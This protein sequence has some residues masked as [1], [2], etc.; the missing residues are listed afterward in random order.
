M[1]HAT[2]SDEGL[3]YA[4]RVYDDRQLVDT[5]YV[6]SLSMEFSDLRNIAREDD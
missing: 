4:I 6:N 3:E 1:I 2:I 5:T